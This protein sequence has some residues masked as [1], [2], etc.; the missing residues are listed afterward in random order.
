MSNE[1]I[2]YGHL[3]ATS[4]ARRCVMTGVKTDS[5]YRPCCG[6]DI[7]YTPAIHSIPAHSL[8]AM[9]LKTLFLRTTASLLFAAYVLFA[10]TFLLFTVLEFVPSLAEHTNLQQIR[11]YAQR[12][13]YQP[14]PTL[15]FIPSRAGHASRLDTD[16]LG[17]QYSPDYGVRTPRSPTTRRTH[18][19]GFERT[20]RRRR[21]RSCSSGIRMSRSA[22]QI[23]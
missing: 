9:L 10:S 6:G 22:R 2:K 11:Y 19:T 13:D 4:V 8:P 16:F 5:R 23:S 14:D 7:C 15:V 12:R 18:R 1:E 3:T 17:D 21:L 20:V